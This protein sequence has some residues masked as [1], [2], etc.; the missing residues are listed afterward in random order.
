MH[1]FRATDLWTYT[2]TIREMF[3]RNTMGWIEGG[4]IP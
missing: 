1:V 4:K 3:G 2:L